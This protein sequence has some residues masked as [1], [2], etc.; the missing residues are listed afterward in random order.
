MVLNAK[1]NNLLRSLFKPPEAK[2]LVYDPPSPRPIQVALQI[3]RANGIKKSRQHLGADMSKIR[4]FL[5]NHV[6]DIFHNYI[7]CSEISPNKALRNQG[8]ELHLFV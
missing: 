7:E 6:C 5:F 8:K 2:N 1:A 4:N 3:L